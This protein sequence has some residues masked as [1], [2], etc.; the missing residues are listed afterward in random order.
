MN[1]G[2]SKGESQKTNDGNSGSGSTSPEAT[3]MYH[4]KKANGETIDAQFLVFREDGTIGYKVNFSG[5]FK[6]LRA[7]EISSISSPNGSVMYDAVKVNEI[8][9]RAEVEFP[10]KVIH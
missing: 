5:D 9:K 3:E 1:T 10:R 8:S 7:S 2:N 6:K 4:I